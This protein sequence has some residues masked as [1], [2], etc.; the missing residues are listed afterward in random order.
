MI[1]IKKGYVPVRIA[2]AYAILGDKDRA[3]Y[4][5]E[6]SYKHRET[7][8]VAADFHLSDLYANRVFDGLRTDPRYRDLARRIGLPP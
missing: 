1:V 2:A 5:L 8:L 3:F 4:W 7:A 6:E